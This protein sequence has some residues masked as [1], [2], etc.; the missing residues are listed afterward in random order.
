MT[1]KKKMRK[2]DAKRQKSMMKSDLPQAIAAVNE[3]NDPINAIKR[4]PLQLPAPVVS[5]EELRRARN[6]LFQLQRHRQCAR[7]CEMS[8]ESTQNNCTE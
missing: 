4:K 3:K 1:T 8:W 5:N 6:C 2:H 7:L